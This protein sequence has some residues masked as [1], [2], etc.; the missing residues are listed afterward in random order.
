LLNTQFVPGFYDLEHIQDQIIIGKSHASQFPPQMTLVER[1]YMAR[2]WSWP[3]KLNDEIIKV[4]QDSFDYFVERIKAGGYVDIEHVL[5]KFLN[6]EHLTEV[7]FVGV[8]GT[9]APNGVGIQN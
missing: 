4:Y 8:Q 9:I 6:R 5:Y 2:L 3:A 7:D 1:Q